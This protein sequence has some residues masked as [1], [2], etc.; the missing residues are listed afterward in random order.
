MAS[1]ALLTWDF[2][3]TFRGLKSDSNLE[4]QFNSWNIQVGQAFKAFLRRPILVESRVD[5]LPTRPRKPLYYLEAAPVTTFTSVEYDPSEEFNAS[6]S[7]G[8]AQHSEYVREDKTGRLKLLFQPSPSDQGLRVTYSGGLVAD[9]ATLLTTTDEHHWLA[10]LACQMVQVLQ[11]RRD[12]PHVESE[13]VGRNNRSY[14]GQLGIPDW[15]AEQLS[16]LRNPIL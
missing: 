1:P 9:V 15:I 12:N 2:Y 4:T 13:G 11:E 6:G 5:L 10:V 8:L 7:W 3:R 16:P 14:G